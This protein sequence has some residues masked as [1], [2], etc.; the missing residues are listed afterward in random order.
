MLVGE[1]PLEQPANH[2]LVNSRFASQPLDESAQIPLAAVMLLRFNSKIGELTARVRRLVAKSRD[3]QLLLTGLSTKPSEL[4]VGWGPVFGH[5]PKDTKSPPP[6]LETR[7]CNAR[8]LQARGRPFEP[9]TA[10]LRGSPPE[11]VPR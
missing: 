11:P 4:A 5:R 9:G 3:L 10:H 1:Q 7:S 6:A 2:V 8:A